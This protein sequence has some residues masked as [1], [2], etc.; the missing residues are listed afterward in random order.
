[1]ASSSPTTL[2]FRILLI[3]IVLDITTRYFEKPPI[4]TQKMK[5][6]KETKDKYENPLKD[7][8]IDTSLDE[9]EDNFVDVN[10]K[11]SKKLKKNDTEE[12]IEEETEKKEKKSKKN[13][14]NFSIAQC[15]I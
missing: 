1:M 10:K 6:K 5:P 2:L 9:D 3:C 13:R 15:K 12:E 7:V 4:R 14:K 11:K 8:E